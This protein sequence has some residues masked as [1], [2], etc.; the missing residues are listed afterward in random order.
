M[1]VDGGRELDALERRKNLW[2]GAPYLHPACTANVQMWLELY[3]LCSKCYC[4]V[5]VYQS[6]LI[7]F[8][9]FLGDG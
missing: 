1:A 2:L 9:R 5:H 7:F 8:E 6:R 4:I 3:L